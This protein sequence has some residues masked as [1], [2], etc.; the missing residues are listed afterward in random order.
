MKD[1]LQIWKQ[2]YKNIFSDGGVLLIFFGA[3]L[4]YPLFYPIPYSNEVLKDV[5]IAVVDM[6]R[7]Q[8]SRK[9]IRMTDANEFVSVFSKPQN[10][11]EAKKQ[12]F[13]S[14]IY[15][16]MLIPQD[17]SK[18]ILK[19]EQ[20]KIVVYAD[21]SYFLF[22][23]QALTGI[24][25]ST[26]TMSA[27]VEIQR[28]LAKG[29]TTEQA[30][31]ARDPLPLIAYPLYNRSGGYATFVIPAILILIL[32][33]TLLIGIGMLGGTAREK[34]ANHFLVAG[35]ESKRG[36]RIIF[37]KSGAYFS[38]YLVH[39]LYFFGILFRVYDF[40]QRADLW[41][42]V[43][44]ITPFILSV[45]FLGIALSELFRNR[46]ISIM[47]LLFTSV[48]ALFLSG[49]SWPPEAIPGWMH[50]LSYLLPST[51]GIEGFLRLNLMGATFMEVINNWLGLWI[52]AI[53]YFF[54]ASLS[55]RRI[56]RRDEVIVTNI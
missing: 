16:I 46:E 37:G 18:S 4:I 17:F 26:A 29:F 15:G 47:V 12:F 3:I 44:F 52:L 21:A 11:A 50:F 14:D 31:A 49:F 33:Q 27:G 39:A 28:M 36:L 13:D 25:H 41:Q 34:K 24:F 32:Q 40:P 9:L 6:N 45:I 8:L 38:I 30:I 48:P 7:S 10:I 2:E 20:A 43:L 55:M 56:M 53:G 51:A 54:L 5:P 19:G 1:V 35:I 23:R 22:Y 42:L